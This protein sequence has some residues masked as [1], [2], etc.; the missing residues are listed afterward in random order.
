MSYRFLEHK[1]VS[2]K[3]IQKLHEQNGVA[4]EKQHWYYMI[5][6]SYWRGFIN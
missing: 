2:N 3:N 6:N 4:N 1:N 5:Y